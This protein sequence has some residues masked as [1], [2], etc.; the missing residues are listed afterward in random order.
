M[1]LTLSTNSPES[2]R[3]SST[4]VAPSPKTYVP[5][6][7]I[8]KEK[9]RNPVSTLNGVGEPRNIGKLVSANSDKRPSDTKEKSL[10]KDSGVNSSVRKFQSKLK[11]FPAFAVN[12]CRIADPAV[13]FPFPRLSRLPGANPRNASREKSGTFEAD[14]PSIYQE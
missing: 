3:V 8:V 13:A 5:V 12:V 7:G 6:V 2:K 1:S 4:S 9:V 11:M 10:K 14:T